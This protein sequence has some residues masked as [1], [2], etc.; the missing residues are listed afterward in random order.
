MDFGCQDLNFFLL[1]FSDFLELRSI[2]HPY[3]Y[4]FIFHK[5]YRLTSTSKSI[6]FVVHCNSVF[7]Y[8]QCNVIKKKLYYTINISETLLK[9]IRPETICRNIT[10]VLFVR[11]IKINYSNSFSK[12]SSMYLNLFYIT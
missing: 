1:S 8:C 9:Q 2:F 11:H 10:Y 12:S 3:Y 6:V 4:L 7:A 5:R